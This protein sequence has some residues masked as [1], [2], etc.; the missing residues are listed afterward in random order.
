MPYLSRG[1][2]GDVLGDGWSDYLATGRG[3]AGGS[4]TS[5]NGDVLY[6]DSEGGP[7]HTVLHATS[8][9][10]KDVE[11]D[12]NSQFFGWTEL[13]KAQFFAAKGVTG[14]LTD[15]VR[16]TATPVA[17]GVST[18]D[19]GAVAANDAA[20]AAAA[21]AD[22]V[23]AAALA[24]S[25]AGSAVVTPHGE[26]L[27][28]AG[29]PHQP[30][31]LDEWWAL[32]GG[33]PRYQTINNQQFDYV[34]EHFQNFSDAEIRSVLGNLYSEYLTAVKAQADLDAAK[35]A[36]ASKPPISIPQTYSE[37]AA[38]PAPSLPLTPRDVSIADP[39]PP[40]RSYFDEPA[41]SGSSSSSTKA[42]IG[43]GVGLAVIVLGS[44]YAS[45]QRPR[46]KR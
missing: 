38:T 31:S 40:A 10:D 25:N 29:V 22:A 24:K 34:V 27:A 20:L 36:P 17:N 19:P 45:S 18:Y 11:K 9:A 42:M 12:P 4:V 3:P 44:A 7:D 39:G 8:G 2:R 33:G 1:R 35:N 13:Q 6:F 43:L 14:L 5:P 37:P 46:S 28:A 32:H 15:A 41:I 30:T 26:A 21:K 16:A 23:V